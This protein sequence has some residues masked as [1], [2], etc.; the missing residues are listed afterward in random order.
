MKI[1]NESKVGALTA[2]AI[3]LIILGYNYM[4]NEGDF[5]KPKTFY[6]VE[7]T[8]A[9][10]LGKGNRVLLNGFKVGFVQE[11][12]YVADRDII[13]AKIKITE[14]IAI[15]ANTEAQIISEDILGTRA[16]KLL[17]DE[18]QQK[19]GNFLKSGT[20]LL[21]SV[22]INRLDELSRTV[23]PMV[24][25]VE[26]MLEYL[27]SVI[28]RSGQLEETLLKT[29]TFMASL[30][31]V[32]SEGASLMRRNQNNFYASL[33]ELKDLLATLNGMDSD[34]EEMV[35]NLNA[36]SGTLNDTDWEN[37]SE[38]FIATLSEISELAANMNQ[39]EGTIGKLINDD[40]AYHAMQD[41]LKNLN[42]LLKDVNKY[43]EKYVPMPWGKRQRRKAK[44]ASAKE[45]YQT[46]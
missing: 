7:Y 46:H 42:A 36:F 20:Q 44:E 25:K 9:P 43:P 8:Q 26:D 21:P 32:A 15:P 10:G 45:S 4:A 33:K 19:Q 5:F 38:T 13:Q 31:S 2:I 6:F 16:I 40:Q 39:G 37:M 27:D 34:L 14:R 22:E 41:A 17:F 28:I 24:H 12:N 23:D 11:L 1:S 3:T 35:A 29:T 30:E 18:E